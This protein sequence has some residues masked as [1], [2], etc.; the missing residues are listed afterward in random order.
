MR[1]EAARGELA[2]N[3]IVWILY[4]VSYPLA[5]LLWRLKFSANFVSALSLIAALAAAFFLVAPR[6][7]AL[8]ATAWVFAMVLDFCDGMVSRMSGTANT[9]A[10][11]LDHFLD[12]TKFSL[13]TLALGMYWDSNEITLILLLST[14]SIFIFLVLNQI[15]FKSSNTDSGAEAMSRSKP[16]DISYWKTAAITLGTFHVGQFLL[17]ALAPIAPWVTIAVY[18][19]IF[20]VGLAM[21]MRVIKILRLHPKALS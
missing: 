16:R 10:F 20:A 2:E 1:Q 11:K 17:I 9:S 18:L 7:L 5:F 8:F 13:I 4:R 3:P 6:N 14:Q 12:L 19:Y 15:S 21:S